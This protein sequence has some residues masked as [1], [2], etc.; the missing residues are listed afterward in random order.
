MKERQKLAGLTLTPA[1]KQWLSFAGCSLLLVGLGLDGI[2]HRLDPTLVEQEGVFSLSNPG[3]LLM[4]FGVGL[5]VFNLVFSLLER[6]RGLKK[7]G[8]LFV[9]AAFW[10]LGLCGVNAVLALQSD[11]IVHGQPSNDAQFSLN[12]ALRLSNTANYTYYYSENEELA[13]EYPL[14]EAQTSLHN[15]HPDA[16]SIF[17]PVNKTFYKASNHARHGQATSPGEK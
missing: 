10:V 5:L 17:Q 7:K 3:H 14:T 16:L 15:S 6:A 1:A 9:V 13:E 2:L 4:G 12:E 8:V 11:G